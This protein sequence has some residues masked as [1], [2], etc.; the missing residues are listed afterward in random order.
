MNCFLSGWAIPPNINH[1]NYKDY[2]FLDSTKIVSEYKTAENIAQNFEKIFPKDTET[3]AA[4]SM[5]TIIVLSVL[6]KIKAKKIILCSPTMKF[7]ANDEILKR[8]NMLRQN[9]SQD[10]QAAINIFSRNCGIPKNLVNAS[11]YTNE[12]LY[13]GLDFLEKTEI[14]FLQVPINTEFTVI[15]G[16]NDKIISCDL[17]IKTAEKLNAKMIS[18]PN[19][20]HFDSLAYFQNMC[21]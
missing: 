10:K 20:K 19:G 13:A 5:G 7:A 4:W 1:N 15:Y 6:E 18:I 12:E 8:L 14:N 11:H 16:E 2:Y 21:P 17:S 3:I 9:I